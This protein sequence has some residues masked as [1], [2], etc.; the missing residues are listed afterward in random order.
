MATETSVSFFGHCEDNDENLL[1]KPQPVTLVRFL[2]TSAP[3]DDWLTTDNQKQEQAA[4]AEEEAAQKEEKDHFTEE[5]ACYI[6][7]FFGIVTPN[8][9]V[10]IVQMVCHG[11]TPDTYFGVREKHGATPLE[12]RQLKHAPDKKFSSFFTLPLVDP[13]PASRLTT[14]AC[15]LP[16]VTLC[17]D[18]KKRA[19]RVV[20]HNGKL[21]L[22][23]NA[24]IFKKQDE[25]S[26]WVRVPCPHKPAGV[27]RYFNGQ[28]DNNVSHLD[29]YQFEVVV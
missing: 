9:P 1:E 21:W 23:N 7:E 14:Y 6:N 17:A 16:Y 13:P 8:L 15:Y 4:T 11:Y 22:P 20:F 27:Q 3:D 5:E 26:K 12:K 10:Q 18:K 25:G 28:H 29:Q 2:S 24:G 19:A